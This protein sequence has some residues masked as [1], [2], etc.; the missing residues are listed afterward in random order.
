V[1]VVG[2]LRVSTSDQA[3]DGQ[4]LDTQ[5]RAIAS[6]V[7]RRG[8]QLVEWQHDTASGKTMRRRPALELTLDRL[9]QGEYD[10]MVVARLD[11]LSRSV[12]DFAQ[13]LDRAGRKGWALVCLD[14]AVDLTTPYGRAMANV[15]AAFAQLERELIS[16]R[17][18]ES[19]RAG[20]ANG[21]IIPPQV[22]VTPDAA[23][24]IVT[25]HGEGRSQRQI[26]RMLTVEGFRAPQGGA[27]AQ[28]TVQMVLKRET[29]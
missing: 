10:G 21:T 9:D 8:W 2:Y 16:Q 15:A 11:R 28:S 25:L 29:A 24:R 19:I 13:I 14:P 4:S 26:A 1:N 7:E 22:K 18:S 3:T 12:G 6:E 5:Q 20:Y 23:T 17:T 27:W